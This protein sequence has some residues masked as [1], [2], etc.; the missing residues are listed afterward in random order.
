MSSGN[1]LTPSVTAVKPSAD[2]EVQPT[3]DSSS[4]DDTKTPGAPV[5][6]VNPLGHEVT[7]LSAVMLNLGQL[8]GSGIF[9][10]PGVVLNSVGSIGLSLSFWA[11]LSDVCAWCDPREQILPDAYFALLSYAELASFFP[12]RSGAEVV[13]LEQ[14]YPRPR[15]FV[16]TAFA[17]IAVL[18]SATNSVVFA[19]YTLTLF[20]L[21]VTDYSQTVVALGVATFSVGVVAASTKWS[22]RAVNVLGIFKVLSLVFV[23]VTGVAVLAGFTRVSDP[24]AN[25]H[26]VWQGS[27]TNPNALATALVKTN[28]AYTGWSNAFNVLGEVKGKSPAR[29][30]RNAGLISIGIVTVLFLTVNVAYIAAV[31]LDEIKG[32]GQLVGGLFFEHVF[33][34]HWA[35]KILPILVAFSC[36]G[37]ITV[38]KARVLREVARQGLLPYATFFAS[39]RPFGTPLG[40]VALKYALT[41]LVISALPARDAFN[42]TVDLA[43]YPSLVFQAATA[44]G[45]WRLRA[46]RAREGLL[47]SPFQVWNIVVV[48]W[49]LNCVFLLVM[50][51]VPPEDGHAD[52][53]FWYATIG[54]LLLCALY[55]YVWI[56]L[57]PRIGG[58][59]IV[60]EIVELG[61]G[62]LTSR[63][64]R[65]YKARSLEERPLL[66]SPDSE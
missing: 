16:P 3:L 33:S 36:V 56:V 24:F 30:A 65:K 31:P 64:T 5:E 14:A 18:L 58:Y 28:F 55:Y 37:N 66:A 49:L 52:V 11:I 15:F 4:T 7:L 46:R 48:L 25:F 38:G 10:V 44:I 47:K 39:T 13:F 43:S 59:Y 34:G 26:N 2:M 29:T 50:P 1:T 17:M 62:A 20:G 54:L 6:K 19:Q 41:V 61:G 63:L 23:A 45:L 12:G 9:S 60:E 27:S 42:F 35:S 21:P 32:S 8:L 57:L 40:P 51:W 22:L 53:S